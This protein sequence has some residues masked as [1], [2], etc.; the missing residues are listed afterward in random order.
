M[1]VGCPRKPED[2]YRSGEVPQT[3]VSCLMW[4]LGTKLK[5]Y[6]VHALNL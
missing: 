4:M 3:V 6:I 5:F 1:C 2:G